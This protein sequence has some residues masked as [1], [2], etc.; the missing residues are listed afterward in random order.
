MDF[1][2]AD[3]FGG[4]GITILICLF[5]NELT[6]QRCLLGWIIGSTWESWHYFQNEILSIK[7]KNPIAK[8]FLYPLSHS[9]WDGIIFASVSCL[10]D[11]LQA[12][13]LLFIWFFCVMIEIIVEFFGNGV[14]WEYNTTLWWN[15]ILVRCKGIDYTVLPIVEWM[16]AP[17]VFCL[18]SK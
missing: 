7:L 6:I 1:F 13:R 10:A 4:W 2:L 18:I 16:I 3:L 11:Y 12:P 17:I 9:Y 14:I 5:A 15:P 8:T